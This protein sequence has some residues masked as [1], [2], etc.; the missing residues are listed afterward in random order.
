VK[1]CVVIPVY[2]H[3]HAIGSV[4]ERLKSFGL[5]CYLINDGSSSDCS[6]K[7]Q[8]I[9]AQESDWITL[10]E[11]EKNGGKGAAVMDG[12]KLASEQGFSH[13]IQVDADGQH[14][15]EDITYFV[16]ASK[17]YPEKLILG[18]PQFDE[19]V[20]KKRLYGRQITN[21]WIWVHT[22]SFSI[23]DGLCGFR[24]YPLASVDALLEST[25]IAQGMDFDIDII[26]KLY[27]QGLHVIN[28]PTHVSYPVDGV[29]HFNMLKDN[30][31]I[32][33]KHTQLFFGMLIRSPN[34]LMRHF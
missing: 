16:E 8:K 3:Q 28:I 9:A 27:W 30:V 31:L 21:L 15:I 12:F 32:T 11:R 2:N 14:K 17:K 33:M 23:K 22:L 34:L 18:A 5:P 26:V 25:V 20:P 13:A 7:L 1:V 6:N 4:V 10:V 19:S 24:C 29:S